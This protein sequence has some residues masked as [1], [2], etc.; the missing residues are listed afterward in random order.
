MLSLTLALA[1]LPGCFALEELEAGRAIME[2]HTP[3]AEKR[4]RAEAEEAKR[5]KPQSYQELVGSW[6]KDANTLNVSP[7]QR[8]AADDPLVPCT[9][10]GK[11]VYTKRSDC[12]ARG[13]RAG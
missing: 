9:H 8:L 11:T 2:A 7:E 6:W 10:G 4:K 5:E 1:F 12:V 13:G 3:A